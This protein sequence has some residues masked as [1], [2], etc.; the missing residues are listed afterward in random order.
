[1]KYLRGLD[2]RILAVVQLSIVGERSNSSLVT[3]LQAR[4]LLDGL[5]KL[6]SDVVEVSVSYP[7]I[8]VYNVPL[9]KGSRM[10][11][12]NEELEKAGLKTTEEEQKIISDLPSIFFAPNVEQLPEDGFL[13]YV[14]L[15]DVWQF[16]DAAPNTVFLVPDTSYDVARVLVENALVFGLRPL[17]LSGLPT[18]IYTPEYESTVWS[19]TRA[20]YQAL[21][22]DLTTAAHTR[23]LLDEQDKT[24]M[25]YEKERVSTKNGNIRG[26]EGVGVYKEDT[27][28]TIA[29]D[30]D[31]IRV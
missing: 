25:D 9:N 5:R 7:T 10:L 6:P 23:E 19:L 31:E 11:N 3:P 28:L 1:M 29:D 27:D 20:S 18:A 17:N 30:S 8:D 2:G 26:N 12:I 22:A 15:Q 21:I 14:V 16:K 13:Q 24:V 4:T